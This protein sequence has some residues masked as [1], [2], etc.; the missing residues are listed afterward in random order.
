MVEHA[1]LAGPA[2]VLRPTDGT[3]TSIPL[4]FGDFSGY[5]IGQRQQ[6]TSTVLR[7]RFADTDQTGI[8]LWERVGGNVWNPDAFRFGICTS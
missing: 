1:E 6:I 2:C 4:I 7:E 5:I 8:I 3:A